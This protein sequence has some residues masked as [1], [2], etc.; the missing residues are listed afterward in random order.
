[1]FGRCTS[2]SRDL[3]PDGSA[4]TSGDVRG[5][6]MDR[7]GRS[8]GASGVRFRS[9]ISASCSRA[10][11]G[12]RRVIDSGQSLF[13]DRPSSLASARQHVAEVVSHPAPIALTESSL[14]KVPPDSS[15][16]SAAGEPPN[17]LSGA[18]RAP[19]DPVASLDRAHASPLDA[20]M[21]RSSD[22]SPAVAL[23]AFSYPEVPLPTLSVT[24]PTPQPATADPPSSILPASAP[25]SLTALW[26]EAVARYMKDTGADSAAIEASAFRSTAD[27]VVYIESQEVKFKSF[28]EDGPQWLRDCLL[29]VAEILETIC[30]PLGETISAVFPPGQFVFAAVGYLVKV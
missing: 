21:R 5:R 29:P 15:N 23:G 30:E 26:N 13:R 22:P 28:R 11:D 1:M 20:S 18:A 27:I 8:L 12:V 25:A 9:A 17:L 6:V 16:S 7:T 4:S 14:L 24:M 19:P 2:S 3:T 10:R